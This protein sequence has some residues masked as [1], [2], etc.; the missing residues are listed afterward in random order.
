MNEENWRLIGDIY[1]VSFKLALWDVESSFLFYVGFPK[2][3]EIF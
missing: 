1:E 3:I 2:T